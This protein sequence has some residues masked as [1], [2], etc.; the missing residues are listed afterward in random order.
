[1]SNL[2]KTT[3]W[4]YADS[5]EDALIEAYQLNKGKTGISIVVDADEIE[6]YEEDTDD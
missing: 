2:Y 1:V 5:Q 6:L 4:I 3:A